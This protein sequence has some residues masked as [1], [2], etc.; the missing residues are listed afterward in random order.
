[1]ELLSV[2]GPAG[3]GHKRHPDPGRFLRAFPHPGPAFETLTGPNRSCELSGLPWHSTISSPPWSWDEL[4]HSTEALEIPPPGFCF[5]KQQPACCNIV[6][7]ELLSG[8]C[9]WNRSMEN[10]TQSVCVTLWIQRTEPDPGGPQ[11]EIDL[12]RL[13]RN[14]EGSASGVGQ[15][16]T[17]GFSSE[18][19]LT[20]LRRQ[21]HSFC[22]SDLP[23]VLGTY[24]RL[25]TRARRA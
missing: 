21:T 22:S 23:C 17:M 13:L 7:R 20:G 15:Q 18:V 24:M 1:M 12:H 25:E 14:V 2:G 11:P 16:C 5:P 19:A 10:V 3:L 4:I 9:V 6:Y 8:D